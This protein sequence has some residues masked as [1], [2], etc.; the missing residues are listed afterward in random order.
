MTM[1]YQLK[2][3][4]RKRHNPR[5]GKETLLNSEAQENNKIIKNLYALN[6]RATNT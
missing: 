1:K 3:D 2:V 6:N 4:F 5:E